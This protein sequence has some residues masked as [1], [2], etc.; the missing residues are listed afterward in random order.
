MEYYYDEANPHTKRMQT[1]FDAHEKTN[2]I[3]KYCEF[4]K[5]K[6]PRVPGS[7]DD[8]GLTDPHGIFDWSF[9]SSSIGMNDIAV[10][11]LLHDPFDIFVWS[12]LSSSPRNDTPS[13][14]LLVCPTIAYFIYYIYST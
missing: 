12:V 11:E 5:G 7:A 2:K 14:A 6:G 10:C 9:L 8:N 1:Y 3:T 4:M 13:Y